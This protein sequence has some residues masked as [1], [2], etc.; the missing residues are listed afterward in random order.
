[1]AL[2]LS[3]AAFLLAF[4]F[5][6][7]TFAPVLQEWNSP[8]MGA[9]AGSKTERTTTREV[10]PLSARMLEDVSRPAKFF[11]TEPI[12]IFLGF[13]LILIYVVNFT[14]LSGFTFIFTQTYDLSAGITSL[15]FVSIAVGALV[16]TAC[17]PLHRAIHKR[18]LRRQ[19]R[20]SQLG[21]D[22]KNEEDLQEQRDPPE[23]RLIPAVISAPLLAISLFW[24]GWTNYPFISPLSAYFATGVFGFSLTGIFVSSYQYIID[25]YETYS[26]SALASITMMRYLASAGMLVA[27]RPMYIGIGVHWTLTFLGILAVL[28]IPAPYYFS[29][30]GKSVRQRS[31]FALKDE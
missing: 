7:E 31:P 5:L 14:F 22:G 18:M 8:Q 6:P 30:S 19:R 17:T 12:I 1:M 2:L 24:L 4:F 9:A 15:A 21:Q 3:V 11:G 25:S 10:K 23:L 13:Y 29:M 27:T 16:N 28:L 26:S 20:R